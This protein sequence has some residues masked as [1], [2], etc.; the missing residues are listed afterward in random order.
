MVINVAEVFYYTAIFSWSGTILSIYQLAGSD[1]ELMELK[2]DLHLI[3]DD[4]KRRLANGEI[5]DQMR[6]ITDG[7]HW[8]HY[9]DN[10]SI[11][12]IEV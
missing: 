9:E 8:S 5:P 6:T 4:Y 2:I 3:H 1:Y 12:S 10:H 11:R 7:L